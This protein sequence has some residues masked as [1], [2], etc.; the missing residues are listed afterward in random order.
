[1]F[2]HASSRDAVRS[3][4]A[5]QSGGTSLALSRSER[6][7]LVDELAVFAAF[8]ACT[9]ADV[10]AL[11]DAGKKFTLPANWV[12]I[13]EGAAAEAFFAI[14]DGRARVFRG[15]RLVAE[16]GPGSVVGEMAMLSGGPRRATVTSTTRLVGLRVGHDGVVE[17]LQAHP[18]LLDALRGVYSTHLPAPRLA[19]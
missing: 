13:A 10:E 17:L 3:G 1:M 5:R 2:G 9:R 6:R 8:A 19:G 16:I 7:A 18:R 11:V 15:R 12:L 14:I 4:Q